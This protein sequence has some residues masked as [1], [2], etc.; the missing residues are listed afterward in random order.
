MS[1]NGCSNKFIYIMYE[2]FNHSM[3][4]WT[5]KFENSVYNYI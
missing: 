4:V 2:K 3:L 5:V 1:G